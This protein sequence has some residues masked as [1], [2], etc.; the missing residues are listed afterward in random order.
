ML[1]TAIQLAREL[2]VIYNKRHISQ[3]KEVRTIPDLKSLYLYQIK[4]TCPLFQE[5]LHEKI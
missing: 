3:Q 1:Q 4:S 2:Q 5:V